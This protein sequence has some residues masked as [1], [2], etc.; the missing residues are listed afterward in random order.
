MFKTILFGIVM[1]ILV[2]SRSLFFDKKPSPP[3][4][5]LVYKPSAVT[6]TTNS[7]VYRPSAVTTTTTTGEKRRYSF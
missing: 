5:S 2:N 1:I 4:N 3:S 7:L 6:T